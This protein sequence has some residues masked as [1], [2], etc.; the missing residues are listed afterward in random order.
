MKRLTNLWRQARKILE[1]NL[2]IYRSHKERVAF[3]DGNIDWT[4]FPRQLFEEHEPVFVLSTGRCGTALIT[5]VFQEIPGV[6]AIY[7]AQPELSEI[8]RGAYAEGLEKFEAYKM[9]ISAARFELVAEAQLRGRRYVET[10][11]RS[12]FFAPHLA[13]LFPKA[14]FLHFV[15]HPGDFVRSAIRR[16][17]YEG[18]FFDMGRI[19]PARGRAAEQWSKMSQYEHCAWLWN[20]TNQY[21]ETFK[22]GSGK[23]KVLTVL[24]EDLFSQVQTTLQILDFL[25][26]PRL[27]ESLIA[28]WLGN[29]VNQQTGGPTLNRFRNWGAEQISDVERWAPLAAKY[30]YKL[31]ETVPLRAAS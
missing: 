19:T 9:A 25:D 28:K 10:N 18:H 13:E 16:K 24:A 22:S 12:T 29:P 26:L 23:G 30:G 27:P 1:I 31:F 8:V 3:D 14:R 7:G 20:E 4:D 15:R 2:E 5:R 6:L 11:N 17:Y 21:I